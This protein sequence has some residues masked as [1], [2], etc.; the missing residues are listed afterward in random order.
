MWEVTGIMKVM[1]MI[2]SELESGTKSMADSVCVCVHACMCVYLFVCYNT[3]T[4]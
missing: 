2:L 3:V 4:V 1:V